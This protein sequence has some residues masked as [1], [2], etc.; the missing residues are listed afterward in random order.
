VRTLVTPRSSPAAGRSFS[1]RPYLVWAHRILG[2]AT[3]LFLII[4]GLTGSILAFH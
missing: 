2:L 1:L 4:A 3:A